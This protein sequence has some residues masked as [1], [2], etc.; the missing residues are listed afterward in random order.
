[1]V[2]VKA[3]NTFKILDILYTQNK[4]VQIAWHINSK[5]IYRNYEVKQN[6]PNECRWGEKWYGIRLLKKLKQT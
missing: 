2:T 6:L 5:N 3:V 1:M 4:K